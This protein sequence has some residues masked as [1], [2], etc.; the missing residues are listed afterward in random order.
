MITLT[1]KV[2]SITQQYLERFGKARVAVYHLVISQQEPFS[3]FLNALM[4]TLRRKDLMPC[5]TWFSTPVPNTRYLFLWC[6]GY[7]KNDL[8]DITP[9]VGNLAT[10]HHFKS[11]CEFDYLAGDLS[12]VN[13]INTRLNNLISWFYS[14]SPQFRQRSYG[15]SALW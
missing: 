7:F 1:S 11:F 4:I 14:P 9:V 3:S 2:N 10:L 12:I 8:S 6:N 15:T 5:Y 13:N